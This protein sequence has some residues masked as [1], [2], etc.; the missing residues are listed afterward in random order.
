MVFGPARLCVVGGLRRGLRRRRSRSR[1]PGEVGS[2]RR[3]RP[4]HAIP[5]S[6]ETSS[7]R[8]IAT[9]AAT[10]ATQA[11]GT[12]RGYFI[13]HSG[14]EI[15]SRVED[16]TLTSA[17]AARAVVH[18][19][20][21]GQRAGEP[22][23]GG[24]EGELYRIELELVEDAGEL[25]RD[26]AQHGI[27]H[28]ET[29]MGFGFGLARRGCS[30]PAVAFAFFAALLASCAATPETVTPPRIEVVGLHAL[31]STA[32]RRHFQVS[33]LSTIKTPSRSRSRTSDSR[34]GSPAKASCKAVRSG[35]R[36]GPDA[37][38]DSARGRQ[39]HRLFA[40]AACSR[41]CRDASNALPYE[42]YGKISL[43]RA[44]RSRC[45]LPFSGEVP[46]SMAGNQ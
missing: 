11:I 21:V 14:I 45:S 40:I 17:E 25:A 38:N 18:A 46:L 42:I 8:A 43:D 16:V 13:A 30:A 32:E 34:C 22:L 10:T 3:R 36:A 5:D 35:D 27:G 37:R 31:K 6:F 12:I 4:K 2:R 26:L 23:L 9:R 24:V 33:L 29:E 20:L 19:G 15:V 7:P 39:R 28:W 41:S 44:S 1:D